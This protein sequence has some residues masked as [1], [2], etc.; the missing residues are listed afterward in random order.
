MGH[1]HV[2][3]STYNILSLYRG[4]TDLKFREMT[5]T[6]IKD[7]EIFLRH[8]K[9]TWNTVSTYMKVLKA[10][11]NRAVDYGFGSIC[12]TVVRTCAHTCRQPTQKSP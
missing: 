12:A 1:C 10:I 11:Y 5:P 3:Q 7:F 8:R 2:Y 6:L 4:N 9:C